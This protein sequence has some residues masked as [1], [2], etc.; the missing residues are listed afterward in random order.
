MFYNQ[1]KNECLSRLKKSEDEY[2]SIRSEVEDRCSK[3]FNERAAIAKDII[4]PVEEYIN[5]LA[6]K[7]IELEKSFNQLQIDYASFSAVFQM[8]KEYSDLVD[9]TA[10]ATAGSGIAIGAGVGA[11][12]PTAAMAVATTF[13]TASTGAAISSLSGAAATNAALAW[14]GGGTIA[15]GGGGMASGGAL[16]AMAGPIGWGIAGLAIVGGAGWKIWKNKK[17]AEE[18][19]IAAK[20]YKSESAILKGV[21]A[22]VSEVY[23][24]T[25][26]HSNGIK[27]QLEYSI[28]NIPKDFKLFS[29]TDAQEMAALINNINALSK[30]LNKRI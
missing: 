2:K 30:L 23:R 25:I 21:K 6:N 10:A 15:A 17:I 9:R 20:K 4:K 29:E 14:L 5:L 18:A 22:E 13:G 7:P 27:G 28:K 19:N 16:L 11:L 24:L 26:E 3:L 12:A 1:L 8:Q